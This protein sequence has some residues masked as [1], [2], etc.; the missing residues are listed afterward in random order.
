MKHRW[1]RQSGE[2][3]APK[4]TTPPNWVFEA[5]NHC[6][7]KPLYH[8]TVFSKRI[9]KPLH[10]KTTIPSYWRFKHSVDTK[11]RC[12]RG[13]SNKK[14]FKT[15]K[16]IR[17]TRKTY[18]KCCSKKSFSGEVVFQKWTSGFW[19]FFAEQR[20]WSGFLVKWFQNLLR[21]P[22][23]TRQDVWLASGL[24]TVRKWSEQY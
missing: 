3:A 16:T 18:L 8:L 6:T 2:T 7:K 22:W 4:T 5:W 15:L 10:Q 12:C 19:H 11:S 13:K 1:S 14:H 24:L 20:W 23:L 9:L 17:S 21:E